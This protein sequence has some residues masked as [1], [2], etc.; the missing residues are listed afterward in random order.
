[1]S[2]I[3]KQK[4]FA[5]IHK[6]LWL[7]GVLLVT[8]GLVFYWLGTIPTLIGVGVLVL[9]VLN[10][11]KM[12]TKLAL[13]IQNARYLSPQQHPSMYQLVAELAQKAGLS[14]LPQVYLIASRK[15]NAFAMGTK[16]APVIGI[17]SGLV[18]YLNKRQLTGVLAHEISHIKNKDILVRG[19]AAFLGNITNIM[20]NVGK[21][22]L[23]LSLPLYLMDIALV[24]WPAMIALLLSPMASV[25]LQLGLSRSMEFIADHDAATLTGDPIGLASALERI[26]A[27][28]RP[29]WHGFN[30]SMKTSNW[31]SSHPSTQER[32]GKLLDIQRAQSNDRT[33]TPI[34]LGYR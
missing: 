17:T 24:P 22:L 31:L 34:V 6:Y 19:I 9:T 10:M 7:G 15:L 5:Y 26:E 18:A 33:V 12:S 4:A 13:R 27:T 3:E 16:V 11:P 20:S 2:R 30:L 32:I 8:L 28:K 23:L 14:K 29:W 21:I 25:L 1:M